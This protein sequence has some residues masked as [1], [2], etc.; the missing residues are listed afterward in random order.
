MGSIQ[1]KWNI[2]F[3]YS[4]V[5]GLWHDP[6]SRFPFI[7]LAIF[8]NIVD[9]SFKVFH[10]IFMIR[11]GRFRSKYFLEVIRNIMTKLVHAAHW[12]MLYCNCKDIAKLTEFFRRF[13]TKKCSLQKIF[14]SAVAIQVLR[15][16]FLIWLDILF[17]DYIDL[18]ATCSFLVNSF[19]DFV[20]ILQYCTFLE[21]FVKEIGIIKG[22]CL[23]FQFEFDVFEYVFTVVKKL[24]NLFEFQIL[25]IVITIFV[26]L[27]NSSY[28]VLFAIS[29]Y[30]NN[31]EHCIGLPK[32][33]SVTLWFMSNNIFVLFM[34]ISL[35]R[36][37]QRLSSMVIM[38]AFIGP[39][40]YWNVNLNSCL[41]MMIWIIAF[42]ISRFSTSIL[43]SSFKFSLIL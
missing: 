14:W 24:N 8:L 42:W 1:I 38:N 5:F 9:V 13:Y 20:I 43:S 11:N 3:Q 17:N 36:Y 32:L 22:K 26:T 33:I 23:K 27:L 25:F 16:T 40:P 4:N 30:K 10:Y 15:L 7:P 19:N 2:I 6:Q 18:A 12:W 37:C 39:I 28:G 34:L 31:L 29:C 21:I 35:V 41:R